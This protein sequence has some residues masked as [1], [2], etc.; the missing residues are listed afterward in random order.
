VSLIRGRPATAVAW[1][2]SSA[3]R[4]CGWRATGDAAAIPRRCC[5]RRSRARSSDEETGNRRIVAM[6]TP[7]LLAPAMVATI[8]RLPA[9]SDSPG[10]SPA[11]L[12]GNQT[13]EARGKPVSADRDTARHGRTGRDRDGPVRPPSVVPHSTGTHRSP[14]ALHD[15]LDSAPSGADS[16]QAD[17]TTR[18]ASVICRSPHV[19]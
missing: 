2:E 6:I 13:Q 18:W 5:V 12:R 4:P 14:D 8:E 11:I 17:S 19:I 15:A 10:H 16:C 7:S 1:H 3:A 9:A